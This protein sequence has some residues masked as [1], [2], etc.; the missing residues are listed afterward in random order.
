MGGGLK[1]SADTQAGDV[2]RYE[3]V[4]QNRLNG[5]TQVV[6][7]AAALSGDPKANCIAH[8]GDVVTIR[9]L[10]GWND[11]G[12]S[13]VIKGEMKHPGNIRNQTRRK[14]KFSSAACGRVRARSVSIWGRA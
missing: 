6:E 13:I 2:T 5:Q 12:A 10:P 8:N 3:W 14:A 7:I 1:P 11:L 4:N 9:Q